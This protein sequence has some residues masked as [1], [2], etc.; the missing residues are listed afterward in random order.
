M[1]TNG[2]DLLPPIEI[3]DY[4]LAVPLE[5]EERAAR[6]FTEE[7]KNLMVAGIDKVLI[8]GKGCVWSS[9]DFSEAFAR[10]NAGLIPVFAPLTELMPKRGPV[11]VAMRCKGSALEGGA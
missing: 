11:S 6:A 9:E 4:Y 5:A 2:F 3:T 8:S 1:N 10:A 7:I